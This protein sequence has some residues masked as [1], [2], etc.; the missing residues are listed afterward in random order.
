MEFVQNLPPLFLTVLV[1]S[2]GPEQA[3]NLIGAHIMMSTMRGDSKPR[4]M[5]GARI[6]SMY[7]VSVIAAGIAIN[8]TCISDGKKLDIG[9]TVNPDT[10]RDPWSLVKDL[11][12]ELAELKKL[13]RSPAQKSRRK[14]PASKRR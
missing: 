2:V 12:D 14:K 8:L 6:E 3:A 5:A 1:E 11:E 9:L 10:I 13:A 7:P 4:Y